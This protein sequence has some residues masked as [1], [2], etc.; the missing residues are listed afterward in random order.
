[1]YLVAGAPVHPVVHNSGLCWRH[2]GGRKVE[3]VITLRFLP[4]IPPDLPRRA[5]MPALGAALAAPAEAKGA[6]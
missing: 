2:P 1:M 5:F 3:G 6:P 4:P